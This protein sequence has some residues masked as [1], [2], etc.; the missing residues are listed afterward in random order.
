LAYIREK[1]LTIVPDT[2]STEGNEDLDFI[3]GLNY[4]NCSITIDNGDK[5]I[6]LNE[7]N[8][9]YQEKLNSNSI[10]EYKINQLNDKKENCFVFIYCYKLEKLDSYTIGVP[11]GNNTS[12]SFI[13]N[14]K[15]NYI[16]FSYPH[17]EQENDINITFKILKE[18]KYNIDIVINNDK[19]ESR[20]I[21]SSETNITLKADKIKEK[22]KGY[23][24]IC[25][26][27]IFAQL[28]GDNESILDIALKSFK[29]LD[30]TTGGGNTGN[31]INKTILLM[32]IVGVIVILI[33]IAIIAIILIK[34]SGSK[35]DLEEK[36]NTV[37]FGQDNNNIDEDD[38][39]LD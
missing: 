3:F 2:H 35:K 12:Q 32:I 27:I 28:E 7:T 37:S 34:S 5:D 23:K 10:K 9:I 22:C 8:K 25:K 6:E 29:K 16:L 39:L 18:G 4:I 36:I 14:N 26:I 20:K 11:L 19:I 17:T 24:D 21:N 33:V 1:S 13:F 38:D 30:A 31:T 15:N